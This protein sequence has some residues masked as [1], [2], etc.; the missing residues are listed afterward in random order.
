MK[1][2]G[3][4]KAEFEKWYIKDTG[5]DPYKLFDWF[6]I[7]EERM[8]FGA[9]VDYFDGVGIWIHSLK[10]LRSGEF[11]I[12]VD[13]TTIITETRQEARQKAIEKANEFRNTLIK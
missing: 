12:D 9:Y 1:L 13:R 5:S 6:Y 8:Q 3:K 7:L 2:T 10:L 4:C 11:S